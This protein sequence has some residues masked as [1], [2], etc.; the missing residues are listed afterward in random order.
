M[1]NERLR[2]I[3]APLLVIPLG[4]VVVM[5]LSFLL[6][7]LVYNLL[8]SVFFPNDPLSFPAGLVRNTFAVVLVLLYLIICRLRLPDLLKA[9]L[10]IGPVATVIVASILGF[11]DRPAVFIPLMLAIPAVCA[12]VLY[13]ARKPWT[14]FYAL[15]IATLV[16]I[17]YAWPGI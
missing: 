15:A 12:V 11:W 17:R 7:A 16:A 14:Y 13:R 1:K 2:S 3:W 4:G 6:Y 10:L 5:A 9:I 8:E